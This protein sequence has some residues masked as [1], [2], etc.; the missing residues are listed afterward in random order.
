MNK[1]E[2]F[3]RVFNEKLEKTNS[4]D[5]AFKKAVWFAYLE[6]FYEGRAEQ[7]TNKSTE[8]SENT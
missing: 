8:I 6:G 5:Q 3:V 4:F 7:N 2:D 1:V